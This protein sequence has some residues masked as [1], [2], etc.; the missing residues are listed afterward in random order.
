MFV[1]NRADTI[2][3]HDGLQANEVRPILYTSVIISP[4]CRAAILGNTGN[5]AVLPRFYVKKH[6]ARSGSGTVVLSV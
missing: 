5:T 2:Q 1:C 3:Y 6:G 4:L